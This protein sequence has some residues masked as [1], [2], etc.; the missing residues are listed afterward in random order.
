MSKVAFAGTQ[1]AWLCEQGADQGSSRVPNPE[2]DPRNSATPLAKCFVTGDAGR[3]W[4]S[5]SVPGTVSTY[6]ARAR[7]DA[8][9]TSLTAIDARQAWAVVR[10]VY[11]FAGGGRESIDLRDQSVLRT[12]DGGITWLTVRRRAPSSDGSPN[13]LAGLPWV[14]FEDVRTGVVGRIPTEPLGG[15]ARRR[16]HLAD[17]ANASAGAGGP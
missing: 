16:R 3:T 2:G 5:G 9:I 8:G 12:T 10:T 4:T 6:T 14:R 13:T 17:G 7:V 1:V 11:L 15:H